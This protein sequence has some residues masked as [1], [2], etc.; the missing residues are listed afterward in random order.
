MSVEYALNTTRFVLT[1]STQA[2]Q[3]VRTMHYCTAD[4]ML[5]S[6]SGTGLYIRSGCAGGSYCYTEGNMIRI[7]SQA[8]AVGHCWKPPINK[9][10]WGVE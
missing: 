3:N 10:T 1:T 2:L 4:F 8:P 5:D 9:S 7:W 6:N